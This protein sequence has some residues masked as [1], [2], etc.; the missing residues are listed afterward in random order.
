MSVNL[1]LLCTSFKQWK[2][3]M[4]R[5]NWNTEISMTSTVSARLA[6]VECHSGASRCSNQNDAP[7]VARRSRVLLAGFMADTVKLSVQGHGPNGRRVRTEQMVKSK[8]CLLLCSKLK[9]AGI[10]LSAGCTRSK[11]ADGVVAHTAHR[12]VHTREQR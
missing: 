8:V 1:E 3:R 9:L 11:H 4:Q 5:K 2:H 6:A 10:R 12:A 7:R